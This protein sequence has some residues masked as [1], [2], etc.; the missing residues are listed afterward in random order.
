MN[1][2]TS[3]ILVLLIVVGTFLLGSAWI[4]KFA[5]EYWTP[6]TTAFI[7]LLLAWLS[8]KTYMRDI[9]ACDVQVKLVASDSDF[10]SDMIYNGHIPTFNTNVINKV[11]IISMLNRSRTS[12]VLKSIK[13]EKG[14]ILRPLVNDA[15]TGFG[16]KMAE[17]DERTVFIPVD[18]KAKEFLLKSKKIGVDEATGLTYWVS[19]KAM[20]SMREELS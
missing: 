19:K 11:A 4:D 14:E 12:F 15:A 17:G 5:A 18:Q 9:P 8:Y 7:S 1:F 16:S 3:L 2:F 20:K 10:I 13:N 6:L